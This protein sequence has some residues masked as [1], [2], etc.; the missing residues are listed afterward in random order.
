MVDHLTSLL[1]VLLPW[2][3]QPF[4]GSG[5]AARIGCG[6]IFTEAGIGGVS[7]QHPSQKKAAHVQAAL[8]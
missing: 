2:K 5:Q 7:F 3:P 6:M 8:I 4:R 1:Y